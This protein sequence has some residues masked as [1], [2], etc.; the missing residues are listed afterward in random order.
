[1]SA[2]RSDPS[3]H[4]ATTRA[5]QRPWPQHP[6]LDD[7]PAGL[8][9]STWGRAAKV[10]Q[11]RVL[12]DHLAAQDGPTLLGMDR[13][14]PKLERWDPAHTVWWREDD[15]ALFASDAVH[16][17]SDVLQTFYDQQPGELTLTAEDARERARTGV[18][19]GARWGQVGDGA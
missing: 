4:G 10:G 19:G 18:D 9:G 15:P 5:A 17:L 7:Q 11:A 2:S 14:G 3:Q 12:A 8:R 16:G 13:N 1:M 6:E